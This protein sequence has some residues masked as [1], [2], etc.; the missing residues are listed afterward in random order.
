MADVLQ[1]V[2]LFLHDFL[3]A[4]QSC[5]KDHSEATL[6]TPLKTSRPLLLKFL[7][8][9]LSPTFGIYYSRLPLFTLSS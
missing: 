1:P 6:F 5:L 4:L 3:L 2:L 7:L 9:Q 8:R